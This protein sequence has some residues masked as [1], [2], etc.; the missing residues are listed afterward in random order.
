MPDWTIPLASIDTSR[1]TCALMFSNR[2]NRWI[3]EAI[4]TA[5]RLIKGV[6]IG[7]SIIAFLPIG[8]SVDSTAGDSF[9]TP[10]ASARRASL[11]WIMILGI[12]PPAAKA[13]FV[14][15]WIACQRQA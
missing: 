1:T 7:R 13:G 8:P 2:S 5:S 14:F 9:C 11:P 15:L 3:S 6:P 12:A 10:W 4:E